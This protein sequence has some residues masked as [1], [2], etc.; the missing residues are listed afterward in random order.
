MQLHFT[1]NSYLNKDRRPPDPRLVFDARVE[2][3][4]A[5]NEIFAECNNTTT[6]CGPHIE[7]DKEELVAVRFGHGRL[8]A[9]RL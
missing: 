8:E 9:V 7:R 6:I 1:L 3:C 2:P 5:Q 4:D